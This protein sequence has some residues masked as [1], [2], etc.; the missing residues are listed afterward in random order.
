MDRINVDKFPELEVTQE[1]LK[2][3]VAF[4]GIMAIGIHYGVDPEVTSEELP[5]D[6]ENNGGMLGLMIRTIRASAATGELLAEI[7]ERAEAKQKAE[8]DSTAEMLLSEIFRED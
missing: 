8:I 1:E 6:I 4:A 5:E 2:Q 3:L 7:I